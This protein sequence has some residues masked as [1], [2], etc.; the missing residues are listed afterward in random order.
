MSISEISQIEKPSDISALPDDESASTAVSAIDDTS[1]EPSFQ[2]NTRPR[3]A[4][5]ILDQL[6]PTEVSNALNPEIKLQKVL[7]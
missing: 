5:V 7:S 2:F 1:M 3:K 4:S 6:V